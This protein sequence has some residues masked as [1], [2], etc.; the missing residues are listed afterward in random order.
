MLPPLLPPNKAYVIFFYGSCLVL[1][2]IIYFI[3]TSTNKSAQGGQVV[4]CVVY[5]TGN[6]TTAG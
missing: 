5:R 6:Q 4:L 2:K 1:Y 3:I